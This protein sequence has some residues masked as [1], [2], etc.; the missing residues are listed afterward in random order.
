MAYLSRYGSLWGAIP[1]TPGR[2]FWVS[3]GDSYTVDGRSYPAS[4]NHDGLSP[5]RAL[6]TLTQ[7]MTNVTASADDVIVLLPGVHSWTASIAASKARVTIMGLPCG[8]GNFI[9]P[10]ASIVTSAANEVINVTAA[11]VEI[12]NLRVI[13]V[14]AQRGIDFT[15]AADRLFI[16]D[17]S[18]DMATPAVSTSTIGI[19][20]TAA[21]IA[22]SHVLI[23]HN[24]FEIDAA[25]GPAIALGDCKDFVV[26]NNTVAVQAAATLAA[27]MTQDGVLGW[28]VYRNNDF[29]CQR[30]GA[31]TIGIR[32]TDIT[33]PSSVGI[34]RN[35][36]GDDVTVPIDDW[37]AGD[38]YIAE[39]YKAQ[40]GA[41]AGG[42]LWS[43]IT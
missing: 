19:G 15:L 29:L 12:A 13:V 38:A 31:I 14:T 39:N 8:A 6:R 24:Y 33:S 42:V 20:A 5:E 1:Q 10:R 11:D 18:F 32:G 37:G 35:F 23:A 2:V 36:F 30:G 4:D 3:P 16:H 22:A 25:Q 41:A 7:A 28:G 40:V 21:T 43:S 27:A 17:C 26:E 34:F 9:R